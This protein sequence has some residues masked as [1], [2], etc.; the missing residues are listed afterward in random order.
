MSMWVLKQSL[1]AEQEENIEALERLRLPIEGVG[2]LTEVKNADECKAMLKLIHPEDP[3]ERLQV[4]TD[5]LW[6]IAKKVGK[7]DVVLVP[8]QHSKAVAMAE[9]TEAYQYEV[10]PEGEDCHFISVKWL[11]P[12]IPLYSFGNN[13][14]VFT[15]ERNTQMKKI[16]Q[17]AVRVAI[18]KKMPGQLDRFAKIRWIIIALMMMRVLHHIYK[19]VSGDASTDM[20]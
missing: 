18:S 3:P 1:T 15:L 4:R 17:K 20:Y 14:S 9:V 10:S 7:E 16:Q 5:D 11:R 8:L 6:R 13:R 2:D 12:S 19:A